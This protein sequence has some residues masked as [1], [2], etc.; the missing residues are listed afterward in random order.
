[1]GGRRQTVT[2]PDRFVPWRLTPR[3]LD[4]VIP[5][6][7]TFFAWLLFPAVFLPVTSSAVAQRSS[8]ANAEALDRV[9]RA[10]TGHET[11]PAETVFTNIEIL[12]GKPASRLPGMME[13]LTGLIGVDCVYCHVEGNFASDDKPAKRTARKHFAL[14]ARLNREEFGG[15]NKVS[16]WTCHHGK[17]IPELMGGGG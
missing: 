14:I 8:S 1:M 4:A 15:Q 7:R 12:K 6:M 11:D 2:A 3:T 17:P 16:C 5:R 13:A 9:K 10:V